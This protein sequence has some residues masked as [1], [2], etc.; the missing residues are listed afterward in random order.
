MLMGKTLLAK[1]LQPA[2]KPRGTDCARN[3]SSPDYCTFPPI[4]FHQ[5]RC[6]GRRLAVECLRI[7][8]RTAGFSG[9]GL[10][11]RQGDERNSN[12]PICRRW[13]QA[14]QWGRIWKM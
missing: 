9:R 6:Q 10:K 3:E 8:R 1:A 11:L 4:P 5:P 12:N 13:R 14:T 7:T 2:I